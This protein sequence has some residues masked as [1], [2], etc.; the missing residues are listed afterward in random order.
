M[1]PNQCA[2]DPSGVWLSLY[3]AKQHMFYT[4]CSTQERVLAEMRPLT[5]WTACLAL[6]E[7]GDLVRALHTA[8]P[9][10]DPAASYI[11]H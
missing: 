11:C 5:D 7:D 6:V 4:D 9:F 3:R 2:Q 8:T 1:N 10:T